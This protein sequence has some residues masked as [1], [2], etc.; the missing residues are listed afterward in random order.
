MN[1]YERRLVHVKVSQKDTVES[2]SLG[3]GFERR[4]LI[5]PVS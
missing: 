4:V 1:S 3:E 2:E 5:K